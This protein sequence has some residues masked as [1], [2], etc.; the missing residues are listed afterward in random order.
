M[1]YYAVPPG[2]PRFGDMNPAVDLSCVPRFGNMNYYAAP[3]GM[4]RFGDMNPTMSRL[5]SSKH[6]S[7]HFQTL[8]FARSSSFSSV[9]SIILI[10]AACTLSS[11]SQRTQC[12]TPLQPEDYLALL[13]PRFP[14]PQFP[15]FIARVPYHGGQINICLSVVLPYYFALASLSQALFHSQLSLTY[16]AM[17]SDEGYI[18]FY[19]TIGLSYGSVC[20]PFQLKDGLYITEIVPVPFDSTVVEFLLDCSIATGMAVDT[21]F[22]VSSSASAV[23]NPLSP[24]DGSLVPVVAIHSSDSTLHSDFATAAALQSLPSVPEPSQHLTG[25]GKLLLDAHR[26]LG[27][28]HDRVLKHMVDANMSGTLRWVPVIIIRSY[29]CY[30]F[31]GQQKHCAPA[32]D[33]NFQDLNLLTCQVLVWDLCGQH[34]VLGLNGEL[35]WFLAVCPRGYPWCAVAD[36]TSALLDLLLRHT[37]GKVG[38]DSV[39]FV[40]SDEGP[41]FVTEAALVKYREWKLDFTVNCPAHHRQ[42]GSVEHGHSV[43]QDCMHTM[44]SHSQY[45][46]VLWLSI[47]LLSEPDTQFIFIQCCLVIVHNHSVNPDKFYPRNLSC[48]YLG[49]GHFKNIHDAKILIPSTE[50]LLTNRTINE[51]FL[52]FKQMANNPAAVRDCFGIIGFQ[53]LVA[54]T[55]VNKR[56]CTCF[57]IGTIV[58]INFQCQWF[59]VLCCDG[60][61]EYSAFELALIFYLDVLP[62]SF[63]MVFDIAVPAA[64]VI[65]TPCLSDDFQTA[66]CSCMLKSPVLLVASLLT[67]MDNSVGAED[68]LSPLLACL[69]HTEPAVCQ[70]VV[71][72]TRENLDGY[73][74]L[75]TMTDRQAQKQPCAPYW[76]SA[77]DI[78]LTRHVELHAHVD[79]DCP[80]ADSVLV[81]STFWVFYLKIN[82]VTRMIDC[83]KTR[84]IAKG[85]P[86]I[87]G[88]DCFDVQVP[89]VP[90]P[91]IR[92]LL[93]ICASENMEL[94]QMDTFTAFISASLKPDEIFYCIPSR[95]TDLGIGSN[96]LQ[97]VWKLCA[98]LEGT[99]PAAMQWTQS[100]GIP[101]SNFGFTPIGSWGVFWMYCESPDKMLLCSHVDDFLLAASSE[102][103]AHHFEKY[104][105]KHHNCHFGLAEEF[106]GIHIVLDCG[107]C[108]YL[109]QS[110]L[111]ARLLEQEFAGIMCSAGLAGNNL[112]YS[113]GLELN[114]WEHLC[115]CSTPFD[116]KLSDT[117]PDDCP[118]VP[119][120]VLVH[121]MQVVPGT[122]IYIL[123]THQDISHSSKL[124]HS[125]H[126]LDRVVHNPGPSHFQAL[127]NVAC[128]LSETVD[129]CFI[130]G[131]W[132]PAD[133]Q[134]PSGFHANVNASHK[135][136]ELNFHVI[137]GVCIFCFGMLLLSRSFVQDQVATSFCETE[138]VAY[139]SGVKDVKYIRLLLI[140]L[141]IFYK[142]GLHSHRQQNCRYSNQAIWHWGVYSLSWT[143]YGSPSFLAYLVVYDQLCPLVTH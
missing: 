103:S 125:V 43:H 68:K 124:S 136:M 51:H 25:A 104:C 58:S 101:I 126:Q 128:S 131:N 33:P 82:S 143:L 120:P 39:C 62:H 129:L 110:A 134:Y 53:N 14:G 64:L 122:L 23:P 95:D 112:C 97:C 2:M 66:L 86:P 116:Y 38:D 83:F 57:D 44:G 74:V 13:Q 65:V 3:P 135:N 132:T 77:K 59:A 15:R 109:S 67:E 108:I 94:Y 34:H 1:N 123:N 17:D 46:A 21:R 138:H 22:I 40:K 88:F 87:L 11:R 4:P 72:N 92:L 142:V 118:A 37:S 69:I 105:S 81:L 18:D 141:H 48:L 41:G 27:H 76:N 73:S 55:L 47:V 10:F 70:C 12:V 133:L 99:C 119:V 111:I 121:W 7:L 107:Q 96:G 54:W 102:G 114:N 49:T 106:V 63:F 29:S 100:S 24:L 56:V 90:M 61:E 45:P 6:L 16:A 117:S 137:T 80:A 42:T 115:P 8:V 9:K 93:D 60:A 89:T 52:S 84:V 75:S 26:R 36:K 20:I 79:V 127:D 98:P 32:T 85:R 19:G 35:H 113:P 30:C 139:S 78:C 140:D 28:V 5:Y 91:Q 31:K 71:P 50:Q 130:V